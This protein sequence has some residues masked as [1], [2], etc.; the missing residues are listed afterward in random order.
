MLRA[1]SS[2]VSIIFASLS[3]GVRGCEYTSHSKRRVIGNQEARRHRRVEGECE[4]I[5][6]YMGLL[7]ITHLAMKDVNL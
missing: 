2:D 3:T 5:S 6:V 1:V 4:S 7:F